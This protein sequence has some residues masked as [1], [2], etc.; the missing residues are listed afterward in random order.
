MT[1]IPSNWGGKSSEHNKDNPFQIGKVTPVAWYQ[2]YAKYSNVDARNSQYD[3]AT[4]AKIRRKA[5][6]ERK[7][8]NSDVVVAIALI[9]L[10]TIISVYFLVDFAT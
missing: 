9:V 4:G 1:D 10:L 7:S 3:K 6:L 5:R 2:D 8:D